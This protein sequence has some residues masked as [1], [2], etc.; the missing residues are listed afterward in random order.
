MKKI[1]LLLFIFVSI[2]FVSSCDPRKRLDSDFSESLF[3]T[4]KQIIEANDSWEANFYF[5][6]YDSNERICYLN[7]DNEDSLIDTSSENEI[8]ILDGFTYLYNISDATKTKRN[9]SSEDILEVKQ[10]INDYRSTL[11]L[12][13]SDES[14][15][16]IEGWDSTILFLVINFSDT[17]F[18]ECLHDSKDA[19]INI[20]FNDDKT[21][22]VEETIEYY[23]YTIT[24]SFNF[25]LGSTDRTK[26][27]YYLPSDLDAYQ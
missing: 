21:F 7:F 15:Y 10:K 18:C 9:Y 16:T 6:Y 24:K 14:K 4:A 12:L 19:T 2:I 25:F 5:Q 3:K 17:E 23:S 20:A 8:Y 26:M 22:T 27:E 11:M 13:L 1:Y